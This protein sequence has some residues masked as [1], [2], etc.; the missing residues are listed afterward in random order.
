MRPIYN[1]RK[2]DKRKK[3]STAETCITGLTL[4]Q[5]LQQ[6]ARLLPPPPP[7]GKHAQAAS[8][9]LPT[10]RAASP[11]SGS[12]LCGDRLSCPSRPQLL[13]CEKDLATPKTGR[14]LC[15]LLSLLC[16]RVSLASD[17]VG[18]TRQRFSFL[19]QCTVFDSP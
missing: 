3:Q 17:A 10:P 19:G 6:G 8:A 16:K 2:R 1:H 15:L 12:G 4:G 18:L 7:I 13:V 14:C 9:Q 11:R 5:A